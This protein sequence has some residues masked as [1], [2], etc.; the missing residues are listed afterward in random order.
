ML[1]GL[2]L[3]N[4]GRC[5]KLH[6]S[7]RSVFPR[8]N[9]E[10]AK[11]IQSPQKRVTMK[12]PLLYGLGMAAATIV[13]TLLQNLL[14]W[15]NDPGSVALGS[16]VGMAAGFIITVV[17]IVLAMRAARAKAP[18][19]S[20]SYG[21]ALGTGVL[22]SLFSA[23]AFAIFFYV[24]M[25]YINPEYADLI[26]ETEMAKLPPNAPREKVEG[27]VRFMTGPIMTALMVVLMTTL[28]GTIY[29]LVIAYFM[30]K[31]AATSPAPAA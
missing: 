3:E 18:D 29:S 5:E 9:R 4:T 6:K 8:R 27:I 13:L 14:G 2:C 12:I 16:R 11:H 1:E 31:P 17:F 26:V 25:Q 30:K 21:R 10:I 15:H 24:Y 7:A 22:T 23:I 20:F 28:F 19:G